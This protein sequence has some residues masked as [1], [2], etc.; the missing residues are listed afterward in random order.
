MIRFNV[1]ICEIQPG[2]ASMLTTDAWLID[3]GE[4]A[5]PKGSPASF[6]AD[7]DIFNSR[8]F[9]EI[10]IEGLT[11][12]SLTITKP[13]DDHEMY[14]TTVMDIDPEDQIVQCNGPESRL[15]DHVLVETCKRVASFYAEIGTEAN[16]WPTETSLSLE[17]FVHASPYSSFLRRI[18]AAGIESPLRLPVEVPRIIREASQL[19]SFQKHISRVTH[20]IAHKYARM[21]VLAITD[22]SLDLDR[23]LLDGLKSGFQSYTATISD[24][25]KGLESLLTLF[26][27]KRSKI[28]VEEVDTIL[29]P[30][31]LGSRQHMYDLAVVSVSIIEKHGLGAAIKSIRELVRPNGFLILAHEVHDPAQCGLYSG[32]A[33][34]S[35]TPLGWSN[36]LNDSGFSQVPGN[37][38][39]YFHDRYSLTLRQADS[40][41]ELP[42]PSSRSPE[43][44][45]VD[46]LLVLGGLTPPTAGIVAAITAQIAPSCTTFTVSA[47]LDDI[48]PEMMTGVNNII[49]LG[50]LDEPVLSSMSSSRLR[51]LQKLIKPDCLCLWV[52]LRATSDNPNHAASIG[53]L[54]TVACEVPGIIVRV[55]DIESLEDAPYT[56]CRAFTRLLRD[57]W[58]KERHPNWLSTLEPEV[59][60]KNRR[61]LVPRVL[62]W[63]PANERLNANRRT[64]SRA[65]NSLE[66]AI[67]IN[68]EKKPAGRGGQYTT[69]IHEIEDQ[70]Q[71]P[72]I[73][74]TYTSVSS[75]RLSSGDLAHLC[76]GQ[77]I[78]EGTTKMTLSRSITSIIT[79]RSELGLDVDASVNQP[80][81]MALLLRYIFSL[82]L[83][84][85]PPLPDILLIEPDD[86]LV[87]CS[88]KILCEQE[89]ALGLPTECSIRYLTADRARSTS[90]GHLSFIHP[91]SSKTSSTTLLSGRQTCVI[92]FS[93]HDSVISKVFS[94]APGSESTSYSQDRLWHLHDNILPGLSESLWKKAVHL[95]IQKSSSLDPSQIANM[96][97]GPDLLDPAKHIGL[98]TVLDWR[99]ERLIPHM[100][101]P[102]IEPGIFSPEK[103]YVLVGL[104]RDIGQSLSRMLIRHGAAHIVLASRNPPDNNPCWKQE[105]ESTGANISIQSI[106]VTDASSVINIRELISDSM[107]PVGGIVNG[108]MVLDDRVFSEMNLET[109]TRVLDPK[110]KGSKNLDEIFNAPDLEFFILMSSFAAIGGHAGQSNYAA[111]NMYMNGLA[112]A[113]RERG[114]VG[115]VLNIGVIYGL[116]FLHREKDTLYKG[117]ERDGYLPIS[118]RDLHHMF[119]EAVVA[120]RPVK[121][122]VVDIVTGLQRFHFNNPNPMHW[123]TDPRFSH[124]TVAEGKDEMNTKSGKDQPSVK[125]LVAAA[126]TAEEIMTVLIPAFVDYLEAQLQLS[127]HT[128]TGDDS[129]S[130]LGVDSLAAVDIRS[131][132][133]K[134]TGCD[135]SI[136]KIIDSGTIRKC[137]YSPTLISTSQT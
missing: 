124:F 49:F 9:M 118:E 61:R 84:S 89:K 131:W 52:T 100:V 96:I 42:S 33:A 30:D 107:P 113:R 29:K 15:T 14:L 69:S 65:I 110:V 35:L 114:L 32:L 5:L 92:D 90:N 105:L 58:V 109:L 47:A 133:W 10:Q 135:V 55:L 78:S 67:E 66:K 103:T 26:P 37:S 39:Q 21:N 56:V 116:G 129:I 91:L 60:I 81:L 34:Q 80:V 74:A 18:Q 27:S 98:F 136:L 51:I 117:L 48:Q 115:S 125:Y 28:I 82:R 87:E 36:A 11:V 57:I 88:Q 83:L 79:S 120:G 44:R 63:K 123:Q 137:K 13:E 97:S 70:V 99:A 72:L 2:D 40:S 23:Y 112:G 43:S 75:I 12:T 73:H 104:T 41:Y 45:N 3:A 111:A 128:V 38:T 127:K 126:E 7:I 22:P 108:A 16:P 85:S 54:R 4:N 59:Y 95:A 130:N 64:I 19:L 76:T 17:A 25:T 134:N 71:G 86:L 102:L 93:S 24:P 68:P 1:A 119:I 101:R 132:F 50:D 94:S 53:L 8:G 122:Q 121:G 6:T 31:K 77:D 62:P 20:Q 106:D 46:H